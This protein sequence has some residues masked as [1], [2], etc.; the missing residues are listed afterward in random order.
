MNPDVAQAIPEL[1]N[2]GILPEEKAHLLLRIARRE[3]VSLNAE[4]H[5]LYYLGVFLITA[6]AGLLV[7]ENYEHIGPLA[8]SCAVGIGA[9]ACLAW[10]ARNAPPF[11]WG[12]TASSH[13]AFEYIL[14]LGMLLAAADLAFVEVQFTPLGAGWP[15]HLLI[16][17]IVMA[18]AAI[19][20]DSRTLVSLA[21]STFAA[22]RGV[23]VSLIEKPLWN[24]AGESV[25]WN[26]VACGILFL[27][28]ADYSIRRKRKP[29]FEPIAAHM[30]WLLILGALVSGGFE[31]SPEGIICIMTLALTGTALAWHAFRKRRFVL[32]A[33]GIFA[34]YI[35]LTQLVFKARLDF[36]LEMLWIAVTSLA[37]IGL[38][39]KAQRKMRDSS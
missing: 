25:R 24:A 34:I 28:M 37:L 26:A 36:E 17:A 14:L 5:L 15:W 7:K 11:T 16:V 2:E 13:P 32:F 8:I 38:L 35:A 6:G 21:L 9:L 31:P 10:T 1:V 19:R 27:L 20:Y 3:L 23:S 4:I 18:A 12:K 30:G 29:H 22:W 39:R 33:F